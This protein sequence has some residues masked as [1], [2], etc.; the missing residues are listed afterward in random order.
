MKDHSVASFANEV[1]AE[2]R[3][4]NSILLDACEKALAAFDGGPIN[5][6][7]DHVDVIAMLRDA[8]ARMED[9]AL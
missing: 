7:R 9:K 8:I 4:D 5:F 6:S 3:E 2:L 1:I